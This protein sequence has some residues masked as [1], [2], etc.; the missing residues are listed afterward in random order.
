MQAP[1]LDGATDQ[2]IYA[3]MQTG[4][5]NMPVFNDN[6]LTPTQKQAIIA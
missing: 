1:S 3:A 2:Q 4:P 6:E 5:E